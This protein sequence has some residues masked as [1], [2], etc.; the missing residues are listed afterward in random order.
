MKKHTKQIISG[1]VLF[2]LGGMIIPVI[3]VVLVFTSLLNDKPL[4]KFTIPGQAI[5]TIEKQGRYYL[6]NDVHTVFEG[7]SYPATGEFPEGLEITLIENQDG[8]PVVFVSDTSI[9][10]LSSDSHKNSIGYFEVDKPGVYILNV[11][12]ETELR[13]CSFGRSFFNTKSILICLTVG[14]LEMLMGVGGFIFIVIGIIN[15]I[16][17]KR[18]DRLDAGSSPT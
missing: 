7:K 13:V 11:F 4:T 3:F 16:K 6:W 14:F 18:R 8:G 5:V 2:I 10:S 12:G 9:T 17:A 1:V 15:L